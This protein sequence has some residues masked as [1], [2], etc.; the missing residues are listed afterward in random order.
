[1]NDQV[2]PGQ[3]TPA[4]AAP[5]VSSDSATLQML[6]QLLLA[7]RQAALEERQE[8]QRANQ[9]RDEQRRINAEY[10]VA[11]KNKAQAICTHKKGG[12]GI[13]GPRIDFAVYAHTFTDNVAYIRCQICGA[14]WRNQDTKEYLVRKGKKIENHTG[15]GWREALDMLSQSTNTP[16]SSEVK[17]AAQPIENS[18]S[19]LE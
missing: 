1:M 7:E 5:P 2:K 11:E 6:V 17:M 12:K 18:V 9:V 4:P 13:K 10:N 15:I 16:S 19:S 8:K 14:K 3:G